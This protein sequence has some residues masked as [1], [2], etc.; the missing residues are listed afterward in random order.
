MN[1]NILN[2]LLALVFPMIASAQTFTA[3][4]SG[5]NEVG[6]GAPAGA[7]IAVVTFNGTQ[8]NYTI[9]VSGFD[10]PTVAH[11]HTGAA[12]TNG[13]ILIDFAPTFVGG[14]A[15]GTVNTASANVSAIL[16]NP[17]GFYVNVHSAQFPGGAVRGQLSGTTTNPGT[18]VSWL[19]VVGKSKGAQGTNFVTDLRLI[20]DSGAVANVTFDYFQASINGQNAP[21]ITKTTTVAPGEEKVL[22]DFV[23]VTLGVDNQ[24]GG[25]KITSDRNVLAI[26]R[27]INDL[28][29]EGLGTTGI[30]V[31]A[32]EEVPT[33][34]VLPFLSQA[35]DP[36]FA[37]GLGFRTNMGYFNPSS[38]PVTA[39]FTARR[40]SDGAIL[41]TAS[42]V[43]PGFSMIQ[44]NVYEIISTVPAADR[45]Q[46]NFY[47]TWTATGPLF[48]YAGIVDNKTGDSVYVD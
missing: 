16:A 8:V 48:V 42:R 29:A 37:A 24:L 9:L 17:A 13:G 39:T 21:T 4:L 45:A 25:L 19:P 6:G 44:N 1:R 10:T 26:A 33:N 5:A 46:A 11:I 41:G 40:A 7:G 15:N 2:L 43:I 28:R 18:T 38:T 20:N 36:D 34:G 32:L 30:A 31:P 22:D 14:S 12:G 27:V 35:S 3:T 23:G 47:V